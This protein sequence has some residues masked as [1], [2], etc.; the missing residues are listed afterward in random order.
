MPLF[1]QHGDKIQIA[2]AC[3]ISPQYLTDIIKAR[4]GAR[5]D[6]AKRIVNAASELGY[7]LSLMDVIDPKESSN[8]LIG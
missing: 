1:W 2:N 7:S 3:E 4:K 5:V 6:L 8:P